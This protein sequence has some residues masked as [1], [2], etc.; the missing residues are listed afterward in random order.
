MVQATTDAERHKGRGEAQTREE[1]ST[2]FMLTHEQ[3]CHRKRAMNELMDHSDLYGCMTSG[4][5][6]ERVASLEPP[7]WRRVVQYAHSNCES[8]INF[9][10][11]GV[12]SALQSRSKSKPI[13]LG[14]DHNETS[15]KAGRIAVGLEACFI[16]KT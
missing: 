16:G 12:P 3:A 10:K 7:H 14:N 11:L 4:D 6:R 8:L 2:M 15:R 1:S 13:R 9:L 5:E